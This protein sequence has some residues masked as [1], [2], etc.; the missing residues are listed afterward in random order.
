MICNELEKSII[1]NFFK[2]L[3]NGGEYR[4]RPIV[5]EGMTITGFEYWDY[6]GYLKFRWNNAR[7]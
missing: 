4:N 6:L 7:G 3:G 5:I 1:H 2:N